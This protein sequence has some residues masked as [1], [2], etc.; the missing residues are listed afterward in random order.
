MNDDEAV[1]ARVFAH[2]DL[3]SLLRCERVCKRW[4]GVARAAP[5]RTFECAYKRTFGGWTK[6][7]LWHQDLMFGSTTWFERCFWRL[8]MGNTRR[9]SVLTNGFIANAELDGGTLWDCA[10]RTH[11][12]RKLQKHLLTNEQL[13][14]TP[15]QVALVERSL[16]LSQVKNLWI[17]AADQLNFCSNTFGLDLW[18]STA[19]GDFFSYNKCCIA[20]PLAACAYVCLSGYDA[21]PLLRSFFVRHT[22]EREMA[23]AFYKCL[24][25]GTQEA[26]DAQRLLSPGSPEFLAKVLGHL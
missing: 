14:F 3:Q 2:L 8:L 23:D 13:A 16:R 12:W 26:R 20:W 17:K 1:L 4:R 24:T 22:R 6:N 25:L 11:L 15:P 5:E 9:P 19:R 21:T 7:G 10:L 18:E